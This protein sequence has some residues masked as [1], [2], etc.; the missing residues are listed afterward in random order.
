VLKD[1]S[2]WHS[3]SFTLRFSVVVTVIEIVLGFSL[4]LLMNKHFPGRKKLL[5]FL[6]MPVMIAPALM[7]VMF[8]LLLNS[9]IGIVPA[10]LSKIGVNISLFSNGSVVP[11][12]MVLDVAQWT[13]FAFLL[14]YSGLQ[15]VPKEMYEAAAVDGAGFLRTVRSVIIPLMLPIVFIT[16]FLR[17]IDAF[18]TFDVIYILT[19]GGPGDRTSTVSIYI[20]KAFSTGNFGTSSAAAVLAAILVLPLVPVVVRRLT[21]SDAKATR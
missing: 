18:R 16:G 11:L 5:S 8:R 7:G 3:V 12:L 6:I 2:F 20:Y 21:A 4:A 10:L 14:F 17:A 9:N 15:T 19:G 13:P 1:T